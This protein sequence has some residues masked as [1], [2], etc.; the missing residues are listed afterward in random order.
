MIK[1]NLL[2]PVLGAS[3]SL[4]AAMTSYLETLNPVLQ[5]ISLVVSIIAGVLTIVHLMRKYRQ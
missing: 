3:T 2:T 4:G 5:F 1:N